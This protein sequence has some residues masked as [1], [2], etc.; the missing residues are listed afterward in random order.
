MVAGGP[1]IKGLKEFN[2]VVISPVFNELA[3]DEKYSSNAAFYTIDVDEE[4]EI[5]QEVGIRAMP[6]FMVFKNGEKVDSFT[7]ADRAKLPA[8][9]AKHAVP[10]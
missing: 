3:T 10:A 7:G 6:T 2:D 8:F 4:E 5:A 1:T 9:I